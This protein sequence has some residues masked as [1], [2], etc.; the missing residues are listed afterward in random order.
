M[1]WR[2]KAMACRRLLPWTPILCV[3]Q[4]TINLLW[5][6]IYLIFQDYKYWKLILFS[7]VKSKEKKE[8]TLGYGKICSYLFWLSDAG[9]VSISAQNPLETWVSCKPKF[10]STVMWS[11]WT[12]GWWLA[13]SLWCCHKVKNNRWVIFLQQTGD[14]QGSWEEAVFTFPE[15]L[16]KLFH[17]DHSDPCLFCFMPWV[18][19][20]LVWF[21]TSPAYSSFN[22]VF[23]G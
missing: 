21:Q 16:W 13:T 2:R 6:L 19:R 1:I 4:P 3:L 10:I 23:T 9:Q 17:V 11:H 7:F 5:F 20:L 15:F 18:E 22:Q 14:S 8:K 12:V